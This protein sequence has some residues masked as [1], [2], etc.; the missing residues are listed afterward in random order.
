MDEKDTDTSQPFPVT[1]VHPGC[2]AAGRFRRQNLPDIFGRQGVFEKVSETNG[3]RGAGP[4]I[5]GKNMFP[6]D[7]TS[8]KQ[9]KRPKVT[10]G[11]GLVT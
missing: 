2:G 6:I 4:V 8:D 7:A 1:A 3:E 5:R 10:P 11:Y 9:S